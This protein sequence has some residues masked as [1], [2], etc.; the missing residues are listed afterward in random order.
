MPNVKC[1]NAEI[2][3]VGYLG[4]LFMLVQQCYSLE[5]IQHQMLPLIL[6]EGGAVRSPGLGLFD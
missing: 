1:N 4:Y 3:S 5:R 2:L 6:L